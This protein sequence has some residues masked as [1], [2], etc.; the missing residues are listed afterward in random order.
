VAE[1]GHFISLLIDVDLLLSWGCVPG[2][3]RALGTASPVR[4]LGLVD[5]ETLAVGRRE[6][7]GRADRAIDGDDAAAGAADQVMVV[8]ADAILL[9]SR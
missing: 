7:G 5:F 6:A 9:A 4:D 1:N 3:G 8:V 2:L